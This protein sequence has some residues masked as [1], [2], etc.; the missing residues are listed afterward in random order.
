MHSKP[1]LGVCVQ[2]KIREHIEHLRT[3][4]NTSF[5]KHYFVVLVLGKVTLILSSD[6]EDQMDGSERN[7][8]LPFFR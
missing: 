5:F 2:I 3:A 6:T 4:Y 7:V 1:Q 8:F